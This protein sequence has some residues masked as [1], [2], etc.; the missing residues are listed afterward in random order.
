MTRKGF[1]F[2][3]EVKNRFYEIGTPSSLAEFKKHIYQRLLVKK[4]A[5]FLDRDGTLNRLCFNRGTGELDSPL[6]AEEFK[7]L[8]KTIPAL[9]ILKSL[10]FTVIV[11]TNQPAAAKGKTT[12]E[13]ICQINHRF[14][15]ILAKQGIFIDD[16]LTCPHH[17][18]GSPDS[19]EPDLIKK[20]EC[21]KPRPGL[22][23]MAIEKFNLDTS[24]SYMAGDSYRDVL[25]GRSVKMKT[26]FLGEYKGT[27]Q[28]DYIF[29][30]LYEFALFLKRTLKKPKNSQDNLD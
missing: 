22:L 1:I 16:L 14:K 15:D 27:H 29:K 2:G 20:C 9:R 30:N 6:R 4:P 8:P 28:P 25:A 19:E 11:V 7:L 23:K 21:R 10:G 18:V 17:P 3:Y 26:V 13:N 12:L 5:V 24:H